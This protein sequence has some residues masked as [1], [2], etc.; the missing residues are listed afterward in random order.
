MARFA[1]SLAE[2]AG[3]KK[4]EVDLFVRRVVLEMATRIIVRSP[5]DT[6]RFRANWRVYSEVRGP[7]LPVSAAVGAEAAR[8]GDFKS[9]VAKVDP[10]G[11]RTIA[12]I[13]AALNAG[14]FSR[15]WVISN[16]L[17]YAWALEHGHSKQAPVGMVGLTI[18]EFGPI[19]TGAGAGLA[20]GSKM[21]MDL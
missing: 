3:Q 8:T 21:G 12:E 9:A 15:R 2:K 4:A 5:V 20:G 16:N 19:A 18:L 6:G 17:P 10:T 11:E 14:K 13:K 1:L 7:I